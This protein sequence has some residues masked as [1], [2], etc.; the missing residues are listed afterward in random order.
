MVQDIWYQQKNMHENTTTDNFLEIYV[1]KIKWFYHNSNKYLIHQI[2]FC[3]EKIL[4]IGMKKNEMA[5]W[6]SKFSLHLE[7]D[8]EEAPGSWF[9]SSPALVIVAIWG[10]N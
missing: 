10:V 1:K 4:K 8:T 6:H 7:S 9:E 3:Y 5:L 2:I